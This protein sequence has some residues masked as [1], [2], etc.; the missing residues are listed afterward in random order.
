MIEKETIIEDVFKAFF[1]LLK[2]NVSTVEL[3]DGSEK[4]I[5]KYSSSYPDFVKDD[6]IDFPIL[7]VGSPDLNWENFTFG[8]K[9]VSGEID[10]DIIDNNKQATDRFMSKI[11]NTIEEAVHDLREEGLRFVDLNS[12][13]YNS[14]A[15][16]EMKLHDKQATF[17]FKY[18]FQRTRAY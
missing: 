3:T 4:E 8:M 14:F 17:S 11:I 12:T 9:E 18:L 13:D 15:R 6:R 7:L 5:A 10:I 1:D 2:E 16:G